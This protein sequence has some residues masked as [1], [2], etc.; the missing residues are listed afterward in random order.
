MWKFNI[1]GTAFT[2]G[3]V[4]EVVLY[5]GSIGLSMPVAIYNVYMYVI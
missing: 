1:V 3:D 4:A 5:A 2:C